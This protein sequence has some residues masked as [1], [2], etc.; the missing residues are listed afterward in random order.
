MLSGSVLLITACWV[1]RFPKWYV[2]P[3][4]LALLVY[5][6]MFQQMFWEMFREYFWLL[7]R[8][9]SQKEQASREMVHIQKG[10][11]DEYMEK[12]MSLFTAVKNIYRR[13]YRTIPPSLV[14]MGRL[15]EERLTK[16]GTQF[17]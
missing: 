12:K 1:I 11:K 14:T 5:P 13:L 4:P 9:I 17:S 16:E 3:L 7:A 10:F 6:I 15:Q 8:G 2:N